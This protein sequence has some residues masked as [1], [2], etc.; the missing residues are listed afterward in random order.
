MVCLIY[1]SS[2]RVFL[3]CGSNGFCA[4]AGLVDDTV[5]GLMAGCS[6]DYGSLMPAMVTLKNEVINAAKGRRFQ[7]MDGLGGVWGVAAVAGASSNIVAEQGGWLGRWC[8]LDRL[9]MNGQVVQGSK[10]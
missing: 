10:M 4:L 6:I 1:G 5:S 7:T 8:S 3:R 9:P 2:C